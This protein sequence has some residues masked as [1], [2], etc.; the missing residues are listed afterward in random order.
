MVS[1]QVK[2]R[3]ISF[4]TPLQL[5]VVVLTQV[6]AS[7]F[8]SHSSTIASYGFNT[9]KCGPF[10]S[11][12]TLIFHVKCKQHKQG[13]FNGQPNSTRIQFVPNW[14]GILSFKLCWVVVYFFLAVFLIPSRELG[15][16]MLSMLCMSNFMDNFNVLTY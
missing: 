8:I 5:Q 4:F 12:A 1:T 3:A 2:M 11:F 16:H 9:C 14:N 15:K 13:V 6:D 10:A 7:P